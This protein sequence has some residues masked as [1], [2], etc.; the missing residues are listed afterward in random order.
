MA[1][2][3]TSAN[4]KSLMQQ[5][6]QYKYNPANI[7]RAVLDYLRNITD[8]KI[9]VVDPTNPF[10]FALESSA[11]NT[12]AFI[13]DNETNTRKQ[14][15][16]AAQTQEDLYLHMSDKDYIDRFATP[17]KTMFKML[18]DLNELKNKMVLDPATGIKKVIIPRNSEFLIAETI[19][20][21]QY[22]IEIK[23]LTHGGFQVVYNTE[24]IS[25]LQPLNTNMINW[26][27]RTYPVSKQK[28]MY[29]EFEVHQ[30]NIQSYKG[31]L[32]ISTGYKKELTFKDQYY[33]CRVY[34]KNN[35]TQNKWREI[36][37]THTDQVYDI[38]DPTAV[39]KV[40]PG[41]LQVMIPQVYFTTN[42]LSGSIRVDIYQTKGEL[43]LLLENYKPSAFSANWLAIDKESIDQATA[44][45]QVI[46]SVFVYSNQSVVGGK[47]E[48]DFETLRQRVIKNSIGSHELP[49]TNVQ[50]ET[51]LENSGFEIVK[52]I[53]VVTN[54][55]FLATKELPA[56]FD[57][58]LVTAGAASIESLV[59]SVDQLKTHA[60]VHNNG[61]R[62]T[63]TPDI[64][65]T[66]ENGII[67]MLPEPER[68]ALLAMSPDLLTDEIA[69]KDYLYTPFHYVL[70]TSVDTFEVRPYYLDKPEVVTCQFVSQNESTQLQVNTHNYSIIKTD[71][72]YKLFVET[73]SNDEYKNLDDSLVHVQLSF[74]ASGETNQAY[75]NGILV[76]RT[77]TN[78]RIYE[79][80][81]LSKF[82]IDDKDYLWLESFYILTQGSQSLSSKL[83]QNFN[84]YYSTS[85]IL[86]GNWSPRQEDT[87]LG[88]FMLPSRIAFINKEVI[89]L[90]FGTALNNLWSSS[91][92]IPAASPYQKYTADIVAIYPED[93]YKK[94][95]VTGDIF[96]FDANG[97]IVY[98]LL[99]KK[100]DP[101]LSAN[102][103]TVYSHR[104]G[105]IVLDATGKP[106]A[107]S[108]NTLVRQIDLM[109]IDGV[110]YF[111]NDIAST[112]YKHTVVS[113]IVSWITFDLAKLSQRLLEQTKLYYY[114]KTTM[115]VIRVMAESGVATS[116]DA[117][118]RF[119][120][121]LYVSDTVYDNVSLRNALALN[122][123]KVIDKNLK[124]TTISVSSI[125]SDL[126]H[127]YANDVIAFKVFG[128]GN[129]QNYQM[130]SI[131]NSGERCSIKKK[132]VALPDGKLIVAEDVTIEFFKHDRL[133]T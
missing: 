91:R 126:K 77:D 80:N 67:K 50:I 127:S 21:L 102:G 119:T 15:P 44:A 41:K 55:V 33:Y 103:D 54:R 51:A 34:F 65:Y 42:Q 107:T 100:G 10:V 104:A 124:N 106:I 52:N 113:T 116:I 46:D 45:F 118:Q 11:V 47:N 22:P 63:L 9:D 128:F 78:E 18:I 70:D 58:K 64:V 23:Q 101:V 31:D 131:L 92:S 43:N 93:I 4:A 35:A 71:F 98:N 26:E 96:T 72:G 99:H 129:E 112:T 130:L 125:T 79:F 74:Y 68:Q 6:A 90:K 30:F 59:A 121:R 69:K 123:I 56:P 108:Q 32:L 82:D 88:L 2:D 122:T 66:N 115:G 111:A 76:G 94:D 40:L 5:V 13:M 27:I 38:H 8:G 114:P 25:P 36:K 28:M 3:E 83:E 87:E 95:P 109:F 105:D 37:T 57:E 132:L 49:V 84:I 20:S 120:V 7:Q 16:S 29:L 14:Y 1:I 53:D 89:T 73:I 81:I 110:Y 62:I 85:A 48:V 24:Q 12:A 60:L 133:L 117:A 97:N 75:Y 39:L 19:F 61:S 86:N 17:A